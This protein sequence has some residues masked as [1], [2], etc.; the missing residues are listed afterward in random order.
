MPSVGHKLLFGSTIRIGTFAAQVLVA[1]FLSPFIIHTLG[2]R[3][4]GFWTLI[5]A[6]I[7]YYGLLDFG[8]SIAVGR[9]MAGAL[10]SNN[11]Q[12]I[13]KVYNT[14]LPIFIA[15]GG[16]ALLITFV[17]AYI[18]P[19]ILTNPEEIP[20][21]RTVILILGCNM[22]I[23]FVARV[24]TGSLHAQMNFHIVSLVQIAA[25]MVRTSLIVLALT[26]GYQILA[27]ACISFF[28]T[29]SS[30]VAYYYYARKKLPALRF[31]S[32]HFSRDTA[33]T[34]F[35]YSFFVIIANVANLLRFQVDGFVI[36]SFLSL[37]AVTHYSIASSLAN[38]FVQFLVKIM[39]VFTPLFSRQEAQKAH[40]AIKET[41][42][43]ATR[44]SVAIS[45]FIAFAMVAW[46]RPFI[47]RWMGVD[48]QD[49]YP[50]LVMLVMGLLPLLSQQPAHSLLMATSKH[51]ILAVINLLEGL[52]NLSLSL[53]LVRYYGILGV[54]LGT[55]FSLFISK[56]I[57][58]PIYFT[59]ISSF[60]YFEYMRNL[61]LYNLKC[62]FSLLI[63]LA[64]TSWLVSADYGDLFLV[65]SLSAFFY[66]L[67]L[68]VVLLDMKD[69]KYFTNA[70]SS[71]LGR[72]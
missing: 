8:L 11:E 66:A 29:S 39:S 52:L 35:S 34:L 5:G 4:Y 42:Y 6:F 26:A 37:A 57:V 60:L 58:F 30:N 22:A 56:L 71:I 1:F 67:F 45:S 40:E 62:L 43:F 47:E 28:T 64:I 18:S 65:G 72:V 69:R 51:K 10:G 54:A 50:C 14:A 3:L 20:L 31:N 33:T 53:I 63:P 13:N 17:I 38:Y 59:K 15:I 61:L 48:Y 19:W 21:F 32:K 36:A 12:A 27:L 41:L 25:L 24:Y 16:I 68:W 55:F 7:G 9:H 23:D 44:I 2:D 49:A 70:L 46:G